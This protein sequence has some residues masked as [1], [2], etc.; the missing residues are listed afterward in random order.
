MCGIAGYTRAKYSN[1]AIEGLHILRTM[2]ATLAPRGPDAEGVKLFDSVALGHRRLS[3]IDL[4]G[5]AQPMCNS[6]LGLN[7]VF[8]GEIYNYRELNTELRALGYRVRTR[9]DTETLLLAYATGR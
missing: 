1:R 2:I 9:S 4:E 3:V 8:N 6:E 7:V 5:G